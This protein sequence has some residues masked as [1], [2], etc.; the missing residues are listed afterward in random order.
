LRIDQAEKFIWPPLAALMPAPR[1]LALP[2]L[3]GVRFCARCRFDAY[4]VAVV[5][6]G[7]AAGDEACIGRQ[8][9]EDFDLAALA[10][11][12]VD[13]DLA[14][15]ILRVDLE[16]IAVTVAQ[17]HR[18]RRQRVCRA[19]A[20]ENFAAGEHAGAGS[21]AGR[22]IDIDQ[23]LARCRVERRCQHAH[24]AVDLRTIGQTQSGG[25]AGRN[26]G[27]LLGRNFGTPFQA[28]AAQ[29]AKQFVAGLHHAAQ[30]GVAAADDAVV[31]GDNARL[32]ESDALALERCYR[33]VDRRFRALLG[34]QV[35]IDQLLRH[36]ATALDPARAVGVG[37][38]FADGSPGSCQVR[39]LL[40]QAG[41][42]TVARELG[43]QLTTAHDAADVD[44]DL[45]H[46]QTTGFGGDHRL[47]PWEDAATDAQLLRPGRLLCL[48]RAHRQRRA[49]GRRRR[50]CGGGLGVAAAGAVG[51]VAAVRGEI[52]GSEGSAEH[53]YGG[54]QEDGQA[55]SGGRRGGHR[56]S[57]R[58]A[59]GGCV[60]MSGQRRLAGSSSGSAIDRQSRFWRS[61]RHCRHWRVNCRRGLQRQVKTWR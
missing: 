39:L 60:R 15:D 47:L 7:A 58:R 40:G 34:D 18:R 37:L 25:L 22:Q 9:R 30:R 2:A 19:A 48:H 31:R 13:L 29:H 10:A 27:Q 36:G 21:A 50:H 32:G 52:K 33:C 23:R 53:E 3:A 41:V 14:D 5:E 57:V 8:R 45:D 4:R 42:D 1:R 51:A 49:L 11:T 17:D 61:G 24:T 56:V 59:L 54:A 12:G 26:A 35:L 6:E 20:G 28:I 46:A 44:G 43:E 16:D 38:G 55:S